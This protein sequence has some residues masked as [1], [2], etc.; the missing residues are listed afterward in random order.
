MNAV[1]IE[2]AIS[3]LAMQPFDA[4]E[5]PYAFL[6]AFG[7]KDTTLKRLRA[8]NSNKSDLQGGGLH[9]VLLT[10]N[11]HIATCAPGQ[12]HATLASLRAGAVSARQKARFNLATDGDR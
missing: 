7:N 8:G 9:G 5:F 3:E 12:T 6:S 10:N 1:E 11:I 4:A 2:A